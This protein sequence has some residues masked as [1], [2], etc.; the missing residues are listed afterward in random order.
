MNDLKQA[1]A[2][3]KT[4]QNSK[5]VI[6]SVLGQGGFGITY[7]A[8]HTVLEK[9][10]AIKEF[11]PSLY[12]ER[13]ENSS[14]GCSANNEK[15]MLKLKTK[16]IKEARHIAS[17]KHPNII[18]IFDIFEEYGTAYYVMDYV[19]GCSLQELVK[20]EGKLPANK[21]FKYIGEIGDALDYIHSR[22]IGHYDVKPGNI[23]I[24]KAD[25]HSVLIDF[26]LSKQFTEND[27]QTS[28]LIGHSNGYAPIEQYDQSEKLTF[29]PTTD[30][31]SL[32][33]TLFFL[34]SGIRPQ[35]STEIVSQGLKIP[36]EIPDKMKRIIRK[37][38]SIP[39]NKRYQSC[40]KLTNDLKDALD[41]NGIVEFVNNIKGTAKKSLKKIGN[42]NQHDEVC[43]L[44]VSE[45]VA[46]ESTSISDTEEARRTIEKTSD[47]SKIFST[48][49]FKR[50]IDWSKKHPQYVK[51]GMM[52][53][54]ILIGGSIAIGII[55]SL[56]FIER[57]A[58]SSYENH[59]SELVSII[60]II[61]FISL[62]WTYI[63]WKDK[64][65]WLN[66]GIEVSLALSWA[67]PIWYDKTLFLMY[68]I[69][70]WL[71]YLWY[72]LPLKM[73]TV[74]LCLFSVIMALTLI[75]LYK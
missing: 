41:T 5:Y 69:G 17:L 74:I 62:L 64:K 32:T 35:T 71:L 57:V 25:D 6:K 4:L 23:L 46:D 54:N 58:F 15:I 59:I 40:E 38:M 45:E 20:L 12:C 53:C 21:V 68:L 66:I 42:N 24:N 22:K 2:K 50:S 27:E 10:V 33:A 36:E 16:F 8:Y 55:E 61:I 44:S 34:L 14:V 51:F 65:K 30:T 7:L 47:Q 60:S 52:L 3:G 19:E 70:L 31:Y 75:G 29:S 73:K 13:V 28:S 67:M 9:D 43:V 37:G 56:T 1:L 18:T 49:I 26:G 63:F 11:F 72:K 39:Q 48:S